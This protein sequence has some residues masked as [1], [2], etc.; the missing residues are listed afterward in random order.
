M[1][2]ISSGLTSVLM[3][4]VIYPGIQAMITQMYV[5]AMKYPVLSF[6]H[7]TFDSTGCLLTIVFI[8][9]HANM[10]GEKEKEGEQR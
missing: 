9:R 6:E 8:S 7:H 5:P 2:D 3:V 1:L 4:N 10:S